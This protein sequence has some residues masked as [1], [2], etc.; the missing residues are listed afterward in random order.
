MRRALILSAVVALVACAKE[1]APPAAKA[2]NCA[3]SEGGKVEASGGWVREQADPAG[4][5]AAYF[6][7]CNGT[8]APATLTG[9]STPAAAVVE[10]HETTRDANG[11]VSMG[12]IDALTLAPGE[13]VVFEP[14][15]KHAMLIDLANA[16]SAGGEETLTL[17]FADGPSLDVKAQARSIAEAAS[18][19]G[20]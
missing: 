9:I 3:A 16:I 1:E 10:M 19:E 15:G 4:T 2:L 20:H 7:L 11:V 13:R 18:H 12:P 17:Q 14:G 5:S 8:M 6:T